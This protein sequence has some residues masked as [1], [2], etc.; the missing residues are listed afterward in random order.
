MQLSSVLSLGFFLVLQFI[1]VWVL[2]QRPK[3]KPTTVRGY[4][5]RFHNHNLSACLILLF[6]FALLWLLLDQIWRFEET[7]QLPQIDLSSTEPTVSSNRAEETPGVELVQLDSC[8]R[9][10]PWTKLKYCMECCPSHPYYIL[11]PTFCNLFLSHSGGLHPSFPPVWKHSN[12]ATK[13][14]ASYFSSAK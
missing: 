8:P 4:I 12:K 14:R 9:G 11:K 7:F 1:L 10:A 2:S 6:T 3:T 13:M 5:T